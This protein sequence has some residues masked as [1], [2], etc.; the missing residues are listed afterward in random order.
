MK[1][2]WVCFELGGF[3]REGVPICIMNTNLDKPP[4]QLAEWNAFKANTDD[5]KR[6]FKMLY[7]G[8]NFTNGE[9][10]NPKIDNDPDFRN[11]LNEA[12]AEIETEFA[13]FRIEEKFFTKRIDVSSPP[14]QS[15][16]GARIPSKLNFET[17]EIRGSDETLSI[18]G[19]QDGA[20]WSA[21]KRVCC[22]HTNDRW[23]IEVEDVLRLTK[24]K[25]V[26]HT[27]TPFRNKQQ[28]TFIPII[29]RI[30]SIDGAPSKLNVIFVE[31]TERT[32]VSPDVFGNFSAMPVTWA[33]Q[34][35][36]LDVGR[37]FRWD[38]I[39]PVQS[40]L[41]NN[42]RNAS[43]EVWAAEAK[44][45]LQSADDIQRELVAI[46]LLTEAK[47][48]G[49]YD[50]DIKESL[51]RK[52]EGY[53]AAREAF[54]NAIESGDRGRMMEELDKIAEVNKAFVE[55]T[56]RQIQRLVSKLDYRPPRDPA[57]VN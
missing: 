45:V 48:Y 38:C 6:F 57:L 23:L 7:V 1:L 46:G 10:I 19:V 24:D 41:K 20:A 54:E 53:P 47:F 27:L 37:R 22:E 49:S 8:G 26:A 25:L 44:T 28:R 39:D 11:R 16:T 21:L 34:F 5:L 36:L 42:L 40:K 51:L 33:A 13:A 55:H 56:V 35:L 43:K 15:P 18:F 2:D 14:T 31:V 52:M 3:R 30:E 9:K 29:T 4:E 32:R 12:V 17:A 50:D